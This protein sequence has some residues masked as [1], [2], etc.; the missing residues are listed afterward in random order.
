MHFMGLLQAP[1]NPFLEPDGSLSSEA[2]AGRL[3]F[4]QAGCAICHADGRFLPLP[5]VP[6]NLPSGVGTGIAPAN[7]PMLLGLWSTGPYLHDHSAATLH[8]VLLQNPFDQH[9][10]T[11]SLSAGELDALVAYVESL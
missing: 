3:V 4:E 6:R 11:S 5:P 2:L 9:G 10:S 8:D 1:Q 7:V